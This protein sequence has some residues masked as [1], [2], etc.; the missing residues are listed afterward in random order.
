MLK[1]IDPLLNADLL[2][3]LAAMGHGDELALVD[4]N[5]P[6]TSHAQRLVRLDGVDAKAA[7]HAILS[8]LPLDTFVDEPL[9]R[10]EVVG[11]PDEVTPVQAEFHK[12]AEAA[13]G[14]VLSMGSLPRDAFY[15]RARAAFA[16]VATSEARPY[17]CFLLVKG[18]IGAAATDTKKVVTSWQK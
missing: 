14:R 10:M 5:F 1:R 4:S 13:E 18:V 6:A 8:V 9:L 12:L 17:G 3:V 2:Y 7:G 11:A 16:V 15:E